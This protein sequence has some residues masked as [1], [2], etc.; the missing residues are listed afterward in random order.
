MNRAS[1]RSSGPA[2]SVTSIITHRVRPGCEAEYE[3]WLDDV[4]GAAHTFDGHQSVEVLRPAPDHGDYTLAVHFDSLD[5]LQG[6][7]DSDVRQS[8]LARLDHLLREDQTV[9]IRTGLE[10]WFTPPAPAPNPPPPAW[11]QWLI[12]LSALYPLIFLVPLAWSPAF[13]NLVVF[14]VPGTRQL[15][16]AATITALLTFVIMPRYTRLVR[17]WLYS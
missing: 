3:Q 2:E 8:Y 16:T 10:F 17:R 9:E 6:W 14:D 11:K 15:V 5:H 1:T 7:L 12:T 4:I 13:H